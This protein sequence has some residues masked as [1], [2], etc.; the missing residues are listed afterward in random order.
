M[1]N[2]SCPQINDNA[3][4]N[5]DI[6]WPRHLSSRETRLLQQLEDDIKYMACQADRT[7]TDFP[8]CLKPPVMEGVDMPCQ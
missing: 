5:R 3:W 2:N 4:I 6:S 8:H 1:S 7:P